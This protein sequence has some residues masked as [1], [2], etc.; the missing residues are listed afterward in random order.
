MPAKLSTPRLA[1]NVGSEPTYGKHS[2]KQAGARRG[3]P[4]RPHC[5]NHAIGGFCTGAKLIRDSEKRPTKNTKARQRRA[6]VP[7]KRGSDES[8]SK[9]ILP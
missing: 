2:E 5:Q 8:L 9:I 4:A 7:G 3:K 1:A 6:G